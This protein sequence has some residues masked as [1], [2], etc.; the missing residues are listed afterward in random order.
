MCGR[1]RYTF[2]VGKFLH[3]ICILRVTFLAVFA[4]VD[5]STFECATRYRLTECYE[6]V[7]CF[8]YMGS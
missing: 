3:Y 4:F 1:V 2:V 5:N 7:P 8:Y 6:C